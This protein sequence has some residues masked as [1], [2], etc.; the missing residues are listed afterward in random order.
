MTPWSSRQLSIGRAKDSFYKEHIAERARA[1]D[2]AGVV[3]KAQALHV[4][5]QLAAAAAAVA[6]SFDIRAVQ[7]AAGDGG[8]L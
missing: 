7:R 2:V 1:A 3:G 6:V 5:L 4:G 8:D